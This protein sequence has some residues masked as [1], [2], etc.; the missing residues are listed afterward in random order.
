M[1]QKHDIGWKKRQARELAKR[2]HSQQ[3]LKPRK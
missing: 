2:G 3:N 1:P